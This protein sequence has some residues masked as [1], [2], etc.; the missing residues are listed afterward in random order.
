MTS[1]RIHNFIEHCKKVRELGISYAEYEAQG[2]TSKGYFST[3]VRDLKKEHITDDLQEVLDFYT[4][5]KNN[6]RRKTVESVDSDHC[7]IDYVRDEENHIIAYK[8]EIPIKNKPA[9]CGSFD[10]NEMNTVYRLYSYYGDSLQQRIVSRQFPELSLI[11]FKRV[12]RA[13]QI[14][15]ASGPFAP[16]MFEEHSEEELLEIQLREKENS[17]LRKAEE[18]QI[19]NNEKLL[20]KYAIENIEL[21]KQLENISKF[22][23]NVPTFDNPITLP[24]TSEHGSNLIL[25]ISDMHI[26]AAVTSGT[27]YNENVGFGTTEAKKRLTNMLKKIQEFSKLDTIVINLLGDNI[28]CCGVDGKTARLDHNMPENMDAR[29]QANAFIQIMMW[30]IDSLIANK[31]CSNIKIYSVPCGNHGG[32]YEYM[33]NKALLA[34]INAKYTNIETV[35]FEQFFGT[36][37]FNKHTWVICHGKDSQ[38]MKK[39]LPL[40]IDEKSKTMLYEFFD[41][42][43]I[44]GDNIHVIKGDLHSNNINSCKKFDYR[45]VLS[46]FGASDYSNYNFSRNSYGVS[47]ELF[48]GDNLLRGTFENL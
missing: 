17:F 35:M 44:H 6:N 30:F 18:Q 28:D 27:L 19:K 40:N 11:D 33:V 38:Y 7:K 29:E 48:I 12:L 9:L 14:T 26:G 34:I 5:G 16:H 25:H 15:K 21:R 20:N 46:L 45:N 47:Y 13:F 43:N 1:K 22:N 32:N 2:R 41:D 36:Y 23:I 24:A 4:S 37:E 3:F 39:G 31:L 8:Y 10:R 42:Q